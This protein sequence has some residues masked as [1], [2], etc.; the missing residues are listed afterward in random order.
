VPEPSR[1]L[2]RILRVER[3]ELPERL[4]RIAGIETLIPSH[5]RVARLRV[6]RYGRCG[7]EADDEYGQKAH[8]PALRGN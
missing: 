7:E 3:L 8:Q 6:C 4:V 2:L 5:D 1:Q